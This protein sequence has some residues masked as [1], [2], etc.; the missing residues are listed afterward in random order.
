VHAASG[1]ECFTSSL[2]PSLLSA[3]VDLYCSLLKTM[4]GSV[5]RQQN[6][7]SQSSVVRNRA[8]LQ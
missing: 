3:V 7:E 5:R 4:L 8:A 6:I 2:R 1:E